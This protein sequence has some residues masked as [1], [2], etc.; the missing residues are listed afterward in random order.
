MKTVLEDCHV[1]GSQDS[2]IK[3]PSLVTVITNESDAGS[4]RKTGS[5]VRQHIEEAREEIKQ[6]KE[7]F[8]QDYEP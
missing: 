3:V 4:P 5:I 6:E 7:L 8:S 2:L 1:C